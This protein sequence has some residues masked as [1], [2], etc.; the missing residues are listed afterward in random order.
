MKCILWPIRK[1]HLKCVSGESKVFSL[2][3]LRRENLGDFPGNVE[4]LDPTKPWVSFFTK[5][6]PLS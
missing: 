3:T 1:V 5:S 2:S 4:K 6:S